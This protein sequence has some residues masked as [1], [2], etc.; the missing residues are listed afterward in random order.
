MPKN[1]ED[2]SAGFDYVYEYKDHL[3]NVRLSYADIDNNGAI[4]PSTE[5]LSET[6]YYPFGL[7][8]KGYNNVVSSNANSSAEK[9]KYQGQELE[10]ELGKDTYAFQWRD[11]D[12]VIGRFN[13]IDRFAEKYV[14]HSPYVFTKNNPVF[15]RE[16]KGD[17]INLANLRDNNKEAYDKLI[18]QL[19]DFT[20]YTLN[21]DDDGNVTVATEKNKRGKEKAIVRRDANGKKIGSSS[22]RKNLR[23]AINHDDTVT[24]NDNPYGK[25]RV[26][27]DANGNYTN[28][29]GL[30]SFEI[31]SYTPSAGL[32]PLTNDIGM[33]FFHELGHTPVGGGHHDPVGAGTDGNFSAGPNV[34]R[35]NKIRRQLGPSYGQRMIYNDIGINHSPTNK[36]GDVYS[37]Y[38]QQSLNQLRNGQTPTSLFLQL[39]N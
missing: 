34:R 7:I 30:D 38:S 19:Q 39:N 37:P 17:S 14:S 31:N 21:V 11:Y 9:Y 29:I 23:N 1:V 33:V 8:H 4:D 12:P 35:V 25:S 32:N 20:G 18:N 28:E 22:A 36:S 6:N 16:I 2:Y 27:L 15:Y 24:V 10:E 5:I 13:K 26:T 3:G